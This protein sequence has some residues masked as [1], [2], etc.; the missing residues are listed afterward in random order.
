M[1][2]FYRTVE[3]IVSMSVTYF[4]YV[5]HMKC[6]LNRRHFSD[7]KTCLWEVVALSERRW[8]T[9]LI[10]LPL[11]SVY[12]FMH[13][14]INSLAE[15]KIQV[16]WS[17]KVCHL[18]WRNLMLQCVEFWIACTKRMEAASFSESSVT[19]YQYDMV[20]YPRGGEFSLTPL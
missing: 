12:F 14:M 15:M 16:L 2:T 4:G 19:V 3:D 5:L 6:L 9:W 11:L 17:V 7:A 8:N 1:D 20:S 18:F 10:H 13:K